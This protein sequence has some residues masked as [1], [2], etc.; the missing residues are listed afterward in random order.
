MKKILAFTVMVLLT[1]AGSFAKG[2]KVKTA[3]VT[4]K[5]KSTV[6]TDFH[7]AFYVYKNGTWVAY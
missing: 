1:T 5:T 2:T 7:P 6:K 4:P 3:T